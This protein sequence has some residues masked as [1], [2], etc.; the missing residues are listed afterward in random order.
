MVNKLVEFRNKTN[1]TQ[2]EV[3]NRMRISL[4]FYQKI[5]KGDRNPSYNFLCGFKEQY[6]TYSIDE[7]FFENQT[8]LKCG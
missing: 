7:I 8:H 5:E 2:K 6:P 4:S 3:A 1:Q